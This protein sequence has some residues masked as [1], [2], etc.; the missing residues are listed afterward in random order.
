MGGNKENTVNFAAVEE[1]LMLC[2]DLQEK[3]KEHGLSHAPAEQ[4]YSHLIGEA[5]ES[6][7]DAIEEAVPKIRGKKTQKE[8]RRRKRE[9]AMEF[10]SCPAPRNEDTL[11]D[12][13]T[14][15]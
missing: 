2:I 9:L 5:A 13:H 11:E 1:M 8:R 6:Q 7:S 3:T 4:V 10:G 15:A 14:A 12:R